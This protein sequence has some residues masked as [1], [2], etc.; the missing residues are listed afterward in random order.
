M[1][2][3]SVSKS[4][5]AVVASAA[6]LLAGC[7]SESGNS[8]AG[9]AAADFP[10]RELSIIAGGGP[11]GGLD[12]ASRQLVSAMGDA[13]VDAKFNVVNNAAGNGNAARAAMLA[14]PHDG[15][16]V[17][18]DS[19]RVILNPLIGST[20]LELDQFTPLAQ[21]TVGDV[22]WVVGKDSPFQT[23][24]DV[25]EAVKKDATS[26]TFGVGSTPS[27]EQLNVL[28]PLR[29]AGVDDLTSLNI[30]NF[31]DGGSVNTEL[32]GGRIDVASTGASEAASLVESGDFRALATSGPD[33]HFPDT[34]TW[35][36]LGYDVEIQHLRGIIGPADMPENT[37]EWWI[38]S[39]RKAT[40]SEDWKQSVEN[41]GL[42]SAFL[43]GD[44]FKT[45]L[46]EERDRMKDIYTEI[47]LIK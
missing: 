7:S 32:L 4:L 12:T 43:P 47:G 34:P 36:D 27:N 41:V 42:K 8:N 10:T 29:A 25:I 44:E 9:G 21:L 2:Q 23:A 13:G 40:E 33:R 30:V 22:A 19:N 11:G 18:A 45:R 28:L 46:E 3:F 35:K 24:E 16:T 37:K 14:A 6:L 1:R 38:E 17:V 20:D 5:A 31:L 26:V 15:Y 39:I